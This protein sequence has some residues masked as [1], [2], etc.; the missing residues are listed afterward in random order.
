VS[1]FAVQ[2]CVVTKYTLDCR[3]RAVIAATT[4]T[5]RSYIIPFIGRES[6]PEHVIDS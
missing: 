6:N 2:Q 4:F 1:H 3:F 5:Y